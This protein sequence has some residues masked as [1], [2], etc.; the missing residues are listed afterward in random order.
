MWE[1]QWIYDL[2]QLYKVGLI[3]NL[4][5]L[6]TAMC[7]WEISTNTFQVP[8]W[9][10]TPTLLDLATI[11]GL[12]P[13]EEDYEPS[14]DTDFKFSNHS[15][16]TYIGEHQGSGDIT[17]APKHISFFTYWMCHYIFLPHGIQITKVYKSLVTRLHGRVNVCLSRL[18]LAS[19]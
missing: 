4:V 7:F 8:F 15:Y 6:L 17:D 16:N 12:W 9:M 18:I 3:C 5:M 14:A 10:V 13:S 19:L 2:I 11:V 1:E